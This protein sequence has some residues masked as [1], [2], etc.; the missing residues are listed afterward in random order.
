MP[1]K[2]GSGT[3]ISHYQLISLLGAGGMGEV[4]LADDVLLAR[5]VAIKFLLPN[6]VGDDEG[7]RRLVHE[8]Q[9]AASL[10]HPNICSVHEVGH[11]GDLTFI[12]MQYVEGETLAR[13][14]ARE[15]MSILEVLAVAIPLADALAEAHAHGI[16]HRD[17]KPGN[18]IVTPRGQVKL[19]DFGLAKSLPQADV[20]EDT[21][22]RS[23]FSTAG[24]VIGTMPYMS[25][26]QTKGRAVDV[27]TDVFSFGIVLYEMITGRHPFMRD[28]AAEIA[29][30]ILTHTPPPITRA[31]PDAPPELQRIVSKGLS[32]DRE[33]RYQTVRDLLIDLRTLRDELQFEAKLERSGVGEPRPDTHHSSGMSHTAAVAAMSSRAVGSGPP[34]DSA[35][36]APRGRRWPLGAAAAALALLGLGLVGVRYLETGDDSLAV[37]PFTYASTDVNR[38]ADPDREYIS[39]GLTEAI[40]NSV[41]QLPE[42]RVIARGSVFRYK[43]TDPD[44]Q[45]VGQQLGVRKVLTGRVVQRGEFLTIG[46]ELVEVRTKRHLWGDSYERRLADLVEVQKVITEQVSRRLRVKSAQE[47]SALVARYSDT[48]GATYDVYL[49][50]RYLLNKRSVPDALRS[51][52]YFNQAIA[53]QP[54]YALAYA[55]L[56]DAYTVLSIF[57]GL[58]PR[59]GFPK[60][61]AAA[62][63]ALEIDP[64]LF[65]GHASLGYIVYLH[66]WDW[67]AAEIEFTRAIELN[68][69]AA[70]AH[71][72]YANFLSTMGRHEEAR[73]EINLALERDPTSAI[74]SA[75]A[76]WFYFYARDY[77]KAV[78]LLTKTLETDSAFAPAYSYL[79][80]ALEAKGD[81]H[82]AIELLRQG[83]TRY[84]TNQEYIAR[85]AR[86]SAVCGDRA[87]AQRVL[88]QLLEMSKRSF[89]A[90]TDV[91]VIYAALGDKDRA[92]EWLERAYGERSVRIV[93]LKV[94]PM[95]DSLR[96]DPRF[97]DLMRRLSFP[98]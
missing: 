81:C 66:D 63:R 3:R 95:F 38:L 86:S 29:A 83:L 94:S 15:P 20:R 89:V 42:V 72:W 35:P 14:I 22:T 17:L 27:R 21:P 30:A 78:D 80:A 43:G 31:A 36:R 91:A 25:P 57:S 73:R 98:Q 41:S 79:S 90:A 11:H 60:A 55:G 71:Q 23:R 16:V 75:L 32:K 53:A 51:L 9:A 93:T 76:G 33:E 37:L 74:D 87:A 12:V 5:R 34:A 1:E 48:G 96:G 45:A 13:R 54:Q 82:A 85:L 49:K 40:I 61:K 18:V 6:S 69:N 77:E 44:P 19:M 70:N 26:E 24:A 28:N 59:E 8:A 4:Y 47:R 52:D 50:G 67:K 97:A 10:D 65:E 7:R 92:F 84:P 64:R 62:L 68:P 39:D 58:P 2:L 46:V 88:Q 56:A